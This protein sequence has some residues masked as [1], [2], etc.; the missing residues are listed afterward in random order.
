MF[1]H[2][3]FNF[4]KLSSGKTLSFLDKFLLL[5][6]VLRHYYGGIISKVF[7]HILKRSSNPQCVTVDSMFYFPNHFLGKCDYE[8]DN[9]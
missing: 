4:V 7:P 1:V 8:F 3:F 2:A 9:S 5:I 6:F